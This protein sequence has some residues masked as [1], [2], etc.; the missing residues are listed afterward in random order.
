MS[1][2]DGVSSIAIRYGWEC[3]ELKPQWGRDSP[4]PSKLAPRSN[5]P[6]V[7]YVLALFSGVLHLGYGIDHLPYSSTEAKEKVQVPPV[8]V[9][10]RHAIERTLPYKIN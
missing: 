10:S 4:H 9:S 3:P 1:I 2:W 7:Q 8:S 5:R 6:L